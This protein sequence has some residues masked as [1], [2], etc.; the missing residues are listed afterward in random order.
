M[1]NSN[2][3]TLKLITKL[4]SVL[5]NL[6]YIKKEG[7]NESQ[8][9]SYVKE[10]DVKNDVHVQFVKHGLVF[11]PRT[12]STSVSQIPITTARGTSPKQLGHVALDWSIIDVESGESISGHI[13]GYA[14]DSD[15]KSGWKAL[16]G[17]LKYLFTTM[18]LIPT[19]DKDPEYDK[20]DEQP[21][22]KPKA[23]PTKNPSDA[24][25]QLDKLKMQAQN[26]DSTTLAGLADRMQTSGKFTAEQIAYVT[27]IT[28]EA[29]TGDVERA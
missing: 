21:T 29:R 12:V 18:F 14:L 26:M 2:N 27:G 9:Y 22:E 13:D 3:P 10:A 8:K 23:K 1:E 5:S 11:V 25:S 19:G 17:V 4:H 15:D 16:A 6:D 7:K 28:P 20:E 24:V